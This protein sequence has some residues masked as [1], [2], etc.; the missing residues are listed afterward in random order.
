MG[1]SELKPQL[2]LVFVSGNLIGMTGSVLSQ[3]TSWDNGKY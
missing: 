3:V 2:S 1:P